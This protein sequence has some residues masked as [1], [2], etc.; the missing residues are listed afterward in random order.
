MTDLS[1]LEQRITVALDRIANGVDTL[2]RPA[3][4]PDPDSIAR[5]GALESELAE[6]RAAKAALEARVAELESSPAV[7][8]APPD[9]DAASRLAALESDLAAEKEARAA[10]ER[11]LAEAVPAGPSATEAEL[12]AELDQAL[13]LKTKLE[14]R[15]ARLEPAAA[16]EPDASA[17]AELSE[18]LEAER[19]AKARLEERLGTLADGHAA[20]M[21]ELRQRHDAMIEQSRD[22]QDRVRGL[23]RRIEEMRQAMQIALEQGAEAITDPHLVNRTMMAELEGLRALRE[24][25]RTELDVLLGALK[26]LVKEGADA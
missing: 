16:P 22:M 21:A 13:A 26:P 7:P 17:T 19:T 25:D 14:S 2:S 5:L 1:E 24:A 3:P 18:A 6:E 8:G 4:G 11:Q 23:R 9:D 15:L 12:R 10:L 20:E